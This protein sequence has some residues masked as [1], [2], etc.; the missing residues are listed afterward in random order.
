[1]ARRRRAARQRGRNAAR[2]RRA[3]QRSGPRDPRAL[4][5]R[6]QRGCDRGR[7][8]QPTRERA[9]RLRGRPRLRRR[10][11]AARRDRADL[12]GAR[13]WHLIPELT[14]RW[15]LRCPYCSNPKDWA[16]IRDGLD[17]D[18]GARVFREG[19]ALGAVHVGLTGGEPSARRDLAAIVRSA[20]DAGLYTHLVTAGTPLPP[21]GL[22]VLLDAGL[23]SVQLSIQD[24]TAAASDRIAGSESFERKLAI[25]RATRTLG[26][27]L[28]LNVV[29]HRENLASVGA[30]IA[31]ARSLDAD[32]LELANAQ[33]DG[34]ALLNRDALLPAR[35]QLDA[36]AQMVGE[37]RAR[38]PR[39][40]LL[41]VLPDYF[42]DRP[43]PCMGGW[44][45]RLMVVAPDGVV[46]PCHAARDLPGLEFWN[47]AERPLRD[48]WLDA[49]GMNAFRGE[50]WMPEPCRSCDQRAIDF[51]GCRCQA[52]RLT[53]DAANT[54]P[55]CGLAPPQ[56]AGVSFR[57]LRP[58]DGSVF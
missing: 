1:R 3:D 2:A 50:A 7:A 51:G 23:R 58:R 17:A 30:L 26:L 25:A 18:A 35:A 44:G 53:G 22:A 19:A 24:A 39:P 56:H 13:P 33:Y 16:S 8:A 15:P 4:R 5:R 47:A 31:L 57:G 6:A 55:A 20:A 40:E 52:F 12:I 49:P 29:L 46:L 32:R 11:G 41:W 27:A 36:A 48:C 54:D 38:N 34:W 43:K 10:D 21:D 9:A 37:E 45:R 14:Y 42:A 28:T